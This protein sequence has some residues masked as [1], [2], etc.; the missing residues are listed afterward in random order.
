[1]SYF[2]QMGDA[3]GLGVATS[4]TSI[5]M[6]LVYHRGQLVWL[7]ECMPLED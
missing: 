7:I 3:S 2:H 5:L 1:M 6:V 4:M